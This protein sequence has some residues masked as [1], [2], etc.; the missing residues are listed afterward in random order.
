VRPAS[1]GEAGGDPGARRSRATWSAEPTRAG[2]S[3][4][5]VVLLCCAA[6][7]FAPQD[8]F[9]GRRIGDGVSPWKDL[10][11]IELC[12]GNDRIGPAGSEVGGACVSTGAPTE[13]ACLADADCRSREMCVCGRCTLKY[14]SVASECGAARVCSFSDKRCLPTCIVDA[15]CVGAGEFCSGG[16]CKARCG[17]TADCQTGE[18]CNDAGRCNIAPC[19]LETDCRAGETCREQRLPRATT[20]PSPIVVGP[21]IV[22]FLEMADPT[23]TERQIWRAASADGRSFAFDPA[24]P[25]IAAGGAPSVIR[26]GDGL[27]M[28]LETPDGIAVADSPVGGNQWSPPRLVIPGDYHA[29]GAVQLSP[30]EVFVYVAEGDRG[31]LALWDGTGAPRHVL[32]MADVTD[33]LMWRAVDHV[34]SPFALV[35]TSPLGQPAI[36]VWFDA[37]GQESEDS[38]QFGVPTPIPPND[39]V[40]FASTLVSEPDR[41]VR[42]PYNPVFDRVQ[43]LLDHRAERAPAVVQIGD[44]AYLLYYVAASADGTQAE[45]IGVARNPSE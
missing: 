37:F 26:F 31:G 40:G 39:S 21:T 34:G 23:G 32:S 36:H 7:G 3:T 13:A 5:Y 33:P 24:E 27:R 6:C 45:G 14:C 44:E 1:G 16:L 35:E 22:L 30:G 15:D 25:I 8:S 10:G 43:A 9:T 29:P 42:Y 19:S 18:L 4:I 2:R 28:F 12:L 41:L 38:I 11:A 17:T 20:E